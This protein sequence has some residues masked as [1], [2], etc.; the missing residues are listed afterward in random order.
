MVED[1]SAYTLRTLLEEL[2]QKIPQFEKGQIFETVKSIYPSSEVAKEKKNIKL[3]G[4]TLT[5]P[6]ALSRKDKSTL[7]KDQS[8]LVSFFKNLSRGDF[9][10]VD[11]AEGNSAKCVNLS[12]NE[13]IIK[14]YYKDEKVT[15]TL[16]DLA[17]GTV[18][19]YRRKISKF[20]G[21]K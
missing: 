9:L 21:G 1:R 13:E 7:I 8:D 11:E 3:E 17:N 16:E 4:R 14:K 5:K 10:M 2:K 20:V 18:R 6:L 12:L 19:L 15:L